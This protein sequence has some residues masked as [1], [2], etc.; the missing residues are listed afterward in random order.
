M[1]NDNKKGL[2]SPLSASELI[3]MYYLDMRAAILETAAVLDRI[4]RA[5]GGDEALSDVRIK[6]IVKGCDILKNSSGARS[7]DFLNLLSVE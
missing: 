2:G 5:P 3:E 7:E 4:E 1:G 6:K